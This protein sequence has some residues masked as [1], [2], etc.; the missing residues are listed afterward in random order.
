MVVIKR[1]WIDFVNCLEFK[2]KCFLRLNERDYLMMEW[3]S[4]RYKKMI[5]TINIE[6]KQDSEDITKDGELICRLNTGKRMVV[7]IDTKEM[8]KKIG[9]TFDENVIWNVK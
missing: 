6:I 8:L 1:K 9:M 5:S 7:N 2:I 4:D 3:Q